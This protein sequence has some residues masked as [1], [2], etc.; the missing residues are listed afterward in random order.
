[1]GL[2]DPFALRIA[3]IRTF[4][5]LPP[6][7][8]LELNRPPDLQPLVQRVLARMADDPSDPHAQVYLAPDFH[9]YRD[10]FQQ[11]I[12]A[13]AASVDAAAADLIEMDCFMPAPPELAPED[14]TEPADLA[15]S[16]CAYLS[17]VGD[18]LPEEAGSLIVVVE[19]GTVG[20]REALGWSLGALA[21]W[22]R[23]DRAKVV[24]VD[25]G[26]APLVPV[27]EP[28]ELRMVRVDFAVPPEELEEEVAAELD[29]EDLDPAQARR[30]QLLAGAFATSG[31]RFDEAETRLTQAL[32]S[33]ESDEAGGD[34]ANILYNL[35]NLH[36]RTG[37]YEDASETLAQ[38]AESALDTDNTP[39]A[40][41][42]LTNLGLSLYHE[43]RGQEAL[44]S[45]GAARRLFQSLNHRPGEAYVVDCTAQVWAPSDPERARALWDEALALYDSIS[46]PH[47]HEVRSGGRADVLE[48]LKRLPT[49]PGDG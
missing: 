22:I 26:P 19:P 42:A 30:L 38:A 44:G 28:V 4:M 13:V 12:D 11:L 18:K 27:S 32:T 48:K 40:A 8:V 43:H 9:G 10:F 35:G 6:F 37:R 20:S 16:T 47:L 24:V 14:E 23:S 5:R 3:Q 17:E 34:R 2:Q 15:L 41:M 33:A 1:M 7:R 36:A 46:A 21:Y 39:L 25:G 29:S 31:G 49:A 45:F